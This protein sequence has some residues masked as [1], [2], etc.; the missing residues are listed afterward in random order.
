MPEKKIRYAVVSG[1][2][3]QPV[4][5]ATLVLKFPQRYDTKKKSEVL[6]CG[7][8]GE[9]V[10]TYTNNAP[11]DVRAYTTTDKFLPS[12]GIWN[13]FSFYENT[14]GTEN[15]LL[16]SFSGDAAKLTNWINNQ[17]LRDMEL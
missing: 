5:G 1:T 3:G 11:E 14:R 17:A 8:N 10:Y 7:P 12:T 6:T 13:Q 16:S 2:T 9:V 15:V 4:P